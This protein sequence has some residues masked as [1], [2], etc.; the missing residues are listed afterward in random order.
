[1]K[2]TLYFCHNCGIKTNLSECPECKSRTTPLLCVYW[3][4]NK[5]VPI[6]DYVDN[7]DD[8]LFKIGND[9]R[10]VFPEERLL[11]ECIL[12]SP[13]KYIN[14]SCWRLPNGT[15]IIDGEKIKFSIKSLVEFDDEVIREV[16]HLNQLKN[17]YETFDTYIDEFTKENQSRYN[18]IDEEAT[19]YLMEEVGNES[20]SNMFISFSGG[21]D[22]T[23][24][25]DI[26]TR[27]LGSKKITHI[28]GDTTL[29]FPETYEYIKRLKQNNRLTPIISA[30]NREKN[31]FEM[32]DTIG[33]PSRVMRW[34]C[35]VF[36]TGAI[37]RYIDSIY[38]NKPRV[39]AFHG[40]RRAESSSRNKY[41]RVSNSPKITKQKVISPIID[42]HDY[43]VW[44]YI[45]TRKLDFNEAY[46]YGFSRVGCWCCP[47]NSH[48]SEFLSKIFH[49][50]QFFPWRDQLIENAKKI[51]KLDPEEYVDSG[52][53][54]AKQGGEGIGY[55]K[56][57]TISFKPCATDEN[58]FNYDLNKP[59]DD[60]LYELFKPFGLVN[61]D[62]GNQRLGEVV[63]LD[64]NHNIII[65][66][67]GKKGQ[68]ELKV[69]I[70][71]LPIAG[72]KNIRD[73]KRKIE[74]QITKFQMCLNCS[75]C[76]SV[77]R[78]DAIKIKK[79]S[80]GIEYKVDENK[81]VHCNECINHFT[82]GCYLKKVLATRD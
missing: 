22:S 66:L 17:S 32:A 39:I 64:K 58:S 55:A 31:F 65:K 1:M 52:A 19:E 60:N 18:Y 81:C 29:E 82:S 5:N 67:Q 16:Y 30:K 6:I 43:D 54:K 75:A 51:G 14:G 74:C 11:L 8:D 2:K 36:K 63:V 35:T 41:D 57:Q 9:I 46:K 53:W 69:S 45:L 26:V 47:N 34:C 28:F 48:W 62:L 21:K 73:A 12:G 78:F 68:T 7:D 27:A 33:P 23:V 38:K 13:L 25:S 49:P 3:S 61:Y 80:N 42:W 72:V 20:F 71:N 50:E 40:I 79:G 24:V 10:P 44:I 4:R 56:N 15:Y 59:I 76:M 70:T 37:T 77:C